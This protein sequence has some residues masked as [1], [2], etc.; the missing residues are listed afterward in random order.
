MYAVDLARP[1]DGVN[2]RQFG[3]VQAGVEQQTENCG[4]A[5]VVE[6]VAVAR[7]KQPDDFGFEEDGG[8]ELAPGT[9]PPS[10]DNFQGLQRE[11]SFHLLLPSLIFGEQ[12]AETALWQEAASDYGVIE[13]G[14]AGDQIRTDDFLLGK[15]A[16]CQLS[17]TRRSI[18]SIATRPRAVNGQTRQTRGLCVLAQRV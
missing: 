11:P 10:A 6:G 2:V 4:V 12:C 18:F 9:G 16:L 13:E 7:L 17:Y 8:R 14:G 5:A 15:Q 1:N 3:A